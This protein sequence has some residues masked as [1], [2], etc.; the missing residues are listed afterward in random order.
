MSKSIKNIII[1]VIILVILGVA[2]FMFFGKTKTPTTT[3]TNTNTAL[4]ITATG[5]APTNSVINPN[6]LSAAEATKISQEFVNQLLNLQAIKL[7]DDIFS[8][9]AFQS[10]QD[11]SIVLVQPG[12]EGRPNPFAP[13]GADEA[14]PNASSTNG[15]VTFTPGETWTTVKLGNINISYPPSW[16]NAPISTVVSGSSNVTVVGYTFNLPGGFT[17]TWGGPQSS[18]TANQYGS[19]QYGVSTKT[20]VKNATVELKGQSPT[21]EVKNSFGELVQRNLQ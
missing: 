13:F 5:A 2:Y 21:P 4:Q 14:N 3:P 18:C 6:P 11:F 1:F 7:N 16:T 8:S 12:N 19:F 9:L 10:L 20:C 17:I 15:D